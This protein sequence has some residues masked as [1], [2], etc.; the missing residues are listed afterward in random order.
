MTRNRACLAEWEYLKGKL[1]PNCLKKL[2]LE[3]PPAERL[4]VWSWLETVRDGDIVQQLVRVMVDA[5]A[6]EFT[7][8]RYARSR[9]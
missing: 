8:L 4:N 6:E 9:K 5:R 1:M 7:G 3:M 2:L